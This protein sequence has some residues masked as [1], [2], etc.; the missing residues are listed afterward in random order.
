MIPV[1]DLHRTCTVRRKGRSALWIDPLSFRYFL[2][3]G[4]PHTQTVH[5]DSLII[6]MA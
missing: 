1:G 4:G 5:L 3:C 6:S 2:G